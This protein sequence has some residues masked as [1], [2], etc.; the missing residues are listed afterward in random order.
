MNTI[1]H[2]IGQDDKVFVVDDDEDIR[3]I[4]KTLLESENY[5]VEEFEHGYDAVARTKK[6]NPKILLLDYFLPGEKAE[7]IISRVKSE[8]NSNNLVIILMSANMHVVMDY[9]KLG[10]TEFIRKP[11]TIDKIF[12]T[13]KKYSN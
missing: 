13:I 2:G 8:S 4:L 7:S 10:V 9:E 3:H 11:F 12:S 5:S 1:S 6:G